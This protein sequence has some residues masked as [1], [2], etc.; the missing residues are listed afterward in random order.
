MDYTRADF[1]TKAAFCVTNDTMSGFSGTV[2][3]SLRSADSRILQSGETEVSAD[4]LSAIWIDEIDFDKTDVRHN[5]L[6]YALVDGEKT[7]SE[8]TA[9]LTAPKHFE[10]EDP[11]LTY[12]VNGDEITVTA[13]RYAK[14]VEIDSP[15]SDFVLSDN[16]FDI[17]GGE[18]KT[19]KLLEGKFGKINLRSVYDIR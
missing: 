12:E 11:S 10:F 1:A 8:G 16:Y 9:L 5:Y 19:V 18:S 17:N 7:V 14:Y 15:D 2:K 13:Q 4:A 3:W 6:S